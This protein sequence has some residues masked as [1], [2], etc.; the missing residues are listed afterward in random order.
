M[1]HFLVHRAAVDGA[2]THALV[3]G[4]GNYP[5]LLGGSAALS[6]DHDGMGQL[7]SPPVSAREVAKWL[8]EHLT[9]P[10][11]PLATVALL[12]SEGRRRPFRNP[13]TG[14]DVPIEA[15]TLANAKEALNE[16]KARGDENDKHRL[17]FYFCGH[18][19]ARGPEVS[20]LLADFGRNANNPLDGAIDF[21]RCHTGM[22]S[23]KARE[24]CYFVD[25]CRAN[26]ETTLGAN[27]YMG[28]PIVLPRAGDLPIPAPPPRKA[29]VYYSTVAGQD[30]F[31]R[32]RKPSP[33]T[34]ALLEGLKG[35]GSDD[36]EGDWRVDTTMLK[37]AIDHF[38]EVSDEGTVQVPATNDLTSFF[39][40]YLDGFPEAAVHVRCE[41]DDATA[42]AAF[43]CREGRKLVA[44]R[45]PKPGEWNVRLPVGSYEFAVQ[46]ASGPYASTRENVYVRPIYRKVPL[47]VSR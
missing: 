31:G 24:Q 29:P 14:R 2:A 38:M 6:P 21:T 34:D 26:S 46:F 8:V 37:R 28:D 1:N 36:S 42:A 33:F 30:A 23:C 4:V 45:R 3:L 43:T 40:H 12:L 44:R 20:L 9:D 25:A 18:G 17:L 39:L 32:P 22:E 11:K 7:T 19:I 5:H 16:W 15:A 35:A 47:K 27:G 10:T 41:P 13:K